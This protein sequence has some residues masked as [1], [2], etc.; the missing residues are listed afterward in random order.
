MKKIYTI[1]VALLL[2]IAAMSQTLNVKVGSVIYQFPAA[3][4]GE[5]TYADGKTVTIMD[6][7]FTLADITEMTIDDTQV[8]NNAVSISYN[9]TSAAVTVAGNVAKYVT[10]IVSGAHVSIIQSNTDAV[11]GDEITYTLTGTT[12]DGEFALGGSYKCSVVLAGVRSPIPAALP[13]I[14]PTASA[15]RSVPRRTRRTP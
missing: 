1:L 7:T 15:F 12:T 4:T 8:T 2:T 3:Q 6:K 10:P 5:M 13:S 14:S 11:D 9:G